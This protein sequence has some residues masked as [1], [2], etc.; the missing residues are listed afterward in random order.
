MHINFLAVLVAALVPMVMGFI[1]YSPKTFAPAWIREA[2]L[3]EEKL[4]GANMGVV[5]G[6][7]FV[8]SFLFAFALQ[9]AVIHQFH[10]GSM[11]FQTGFEDP[12]TE[13]GAMYKIIMDQYGTAYRTFKHG[14]L[15]GT[16]TG[17]FMITPVIV[18][19][20]L[21]ERRSF[22]YMAISFGYWIIC[23]AIMGGILSAWV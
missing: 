21:F 11:L 6:V 7:S 22:K 9:F 2:G 23:C 1:W 12:N 19:S 18:I 8:M 17:L 10:F 16:I 4:K 5:F 14:A 15:H 13:I 20:A 3:S